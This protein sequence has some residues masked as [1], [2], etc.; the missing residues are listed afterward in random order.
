MTILS[1]PKNVISAATFLRYG[2]NVIVVGIKVTFAVQKG[3]IAVQKGTIAT[4][5]EVE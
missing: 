4:F 5:F 1:I 3:A 2:I